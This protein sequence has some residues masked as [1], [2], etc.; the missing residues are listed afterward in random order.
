MNR[1]S[2]KAGDT[3]GKVMKIIKPRLCSRHLLWLENP[4]CNARFT[5]L[6]LNI[7]MNMLSAQSRSNFA[8]H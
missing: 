5:I 6:L 2:R 7:F 3:N 1:W 4:R 8:S